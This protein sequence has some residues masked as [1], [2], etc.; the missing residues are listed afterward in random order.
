MR[1]LR[2]LG[3]CGFAVSG[4][5]ALL[6]LGQIPI[7]PATVNLR[8]MTRYPQTRGSF[9]QPHT[10]ASPTWTERNVYLE[11]RAIPGPQASAGAANH[12]IGGR[13]VVCRAHFALRRNARRAPP[14]TTGVP[15]VSAKTT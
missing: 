3:F 9:G 8:A 13:E 5:T 6:S 14:S 15:N 10:G 12:A 7:L 4:W 2:L 11:R 1:L